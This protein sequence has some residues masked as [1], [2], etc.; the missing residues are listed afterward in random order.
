MTNL[1][2]MQDINFYVSEGSKDH[3]VYSA[4][5]EIFNLLVYDFHLC[6]I[7]VGGTIL[8]VGANIGLFARYVLD[9]DSLG[10]GTKVIC[11]EPSLNCLPSLHKNLEETVTIIEKAVWSSSGVI[12]FIENDYA[13]GCSY[14]AGIGVPGDN[15]SEVEITTIDNIVNELNIEN[16]DF[17]KMDIEG[18]EVEALKGAEQTIKSQVPKMAIC[19]YH[20]PDDEKDI[21]DYVMSLVDYKRTVI[22]HA[23]PAFDVKVIYFYR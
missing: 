17:I 19:A 18:S 21:I 9:K 14:V 15:T 23:H 8:D 12:N 3:L 6:A 22:S 16:V 13:P 4:Y 20:R 10:E 11:I 1:R 5:N 2:L 7:P